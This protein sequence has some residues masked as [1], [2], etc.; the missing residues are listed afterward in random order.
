M[1]PRLTEVVEFVDFQEG[2][3]RRH[4]RFTDI[5][6]QRAASYPWLLLGCLLSKE[7]TQQT[8][9]LLGCL[10]RQEVTTRQAVVA[11][12]LGSLAP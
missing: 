3:E 8:S 12:V 7:I 5:P 1:L 11:H 2:L 9:Q 6:R 10:F 4:I